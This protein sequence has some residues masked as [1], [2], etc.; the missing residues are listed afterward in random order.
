MSETGGR[1]SLPVV[2]RG[3][4]CVVESDRECATAFAGDIAPCS[5]PRTTGTTSSPPDCAKGNHLAT[6]V[7]RHSFSRVSPL[8]L[9]PR[10]EAALFDLTRSGLLPVPWPTRERYSGGANANPRWRED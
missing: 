10:L 8:I 6:M 1:S 2:E 4:R 5:A 7:A 3:S 9:P